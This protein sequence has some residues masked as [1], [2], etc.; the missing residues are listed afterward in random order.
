VTQFELFVA[1]RYI[2]SRRKE[3][4]ISIIALISV[5]GVAIGVMALVIALGVNNGFRSTLQRN[6]LGAMAHI[7]V[8][9]KQPGQG[10]DNWRELSAQFR[11]VPHVA[12]VSP[13]FY[14]AG[15]LVSGGLR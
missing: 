7:N 8:I 12:A 4:V 9:P 14:D 11:K 10:I 1:S 13:A 5:I 3:K 2:R 6:L 15:V